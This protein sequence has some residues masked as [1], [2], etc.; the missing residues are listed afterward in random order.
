MPTDPHPA[1]EELLASDDPDERLRGVQL[2]RIRPGP[3]ADRALVEALSD[4]DDE[5]SGAAAAALA[6]RGAAEAVPALVEELAR[7]DRFPGEYVMSVPYLVALEE[8]GGAR[9]WKPLVEALEGMLDGDFEPEAKGRIAVAL[10]RLADPRARPALEALL[11]RA[12]SHEQGGPVAESARGIL[13]QI[14][15]AEARAER[16]PGPEAIRRGLGADDYDEKEAAGRRADEWAR[17]A[18]TGQLIDALADDT[19]ALSSAAARE[20]GIRGPEKAVPALVREVAS[21]EHCVGSQVAAYPYA[22]ASDLRFSEHARALVRI[23]DRSAVEPLA[24]A[25][26]GAPDAWVQRE[27]AWVLGRLGDPRAREAVDEQ[28]AML[29]DVDGSGWRYRSLLSTLRRASARLA[30]AEE[31]EA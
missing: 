19:P 7:A 2:L 29:E 28:L 25:L 16:F 18:A 4:P 6:D 23:G 5:V 12:D 26:P 22:E 31:R 3:G 13:E 27:I 14:E 30:E 20:L 17:Q 21:G 1:H 10:R 9:A 24:G 8:L 15:A 11:E